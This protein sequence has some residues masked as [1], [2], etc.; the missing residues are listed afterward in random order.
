LTTGAKRGQTIFSSPFMGFQVES[1]AVAIAAKAKKAKP[2][3]G[4]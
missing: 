1:T 3:K 2:L 4:G